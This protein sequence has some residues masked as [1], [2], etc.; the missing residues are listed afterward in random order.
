MAGWH[1]RL[2]E[3]EFEQTPGDRGRQRK[4]ACCSPWGHSV[5]HDLA[6][7]QQ[8]QRVTAQLQRGVAT[9]SFCDED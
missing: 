3:L 9:I 8:K 7:E 4:L 6:T 2:N 1:H 5:R